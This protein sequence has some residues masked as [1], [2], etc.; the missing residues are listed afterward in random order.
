MIDSTLNPELLYQLQPICEAVKFDDDL[1]IQFD[2]ESV[3]TTS[4]DV[5][6]TSFERDQEDSLTLALRNILY[7]RCYAHPF[8]QNILPYPQRHDETH[9]DLTTELSAA[10]K[11][12]PRWHTHWVVDAITPEGCYWVVKNGERQKLWPGEFICAHG[13]GQAASIGSH[14]HIHRPV[15]ASH[16]QP[17]FY[18]AF[19]ET[20]EP[21][22]DQNELVRFYWNVRVEEAEKLV[23]AI[24][25]EFNRYQIPFRFKCTN[26]SSLFSRVD[27]AVLYLS[28]EHFRLGLH[29]VMDIH[30]AIESALDSDVPL[31]TY[32][33]ASGLS[34][35]QN[36]P[37]NSS[38]GMERCL[39]LA[40]AIRQSHAQASDT[41]QTGVNGVLQQLENDGLNLQKTHL[42]PN[43]RDRF[44][45]HLEGNGYEH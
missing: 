32:A 21:D 26:L 1:N 9:E 42:T 30:N 29:L 37:G 12:Q 31:F 45:Q 16:W 35:A 22:F 24:T 38:F 43:S 28:V 8:S 18:H 2:N 40:K 15:E 23:S 7:Q 14:I 5:Y 10:N 4:H 6:S 20:H 25:S 11:G 13:T 34:F 33:L 19:G 27:T 44:S 36:P 41:E 3:V 39:R 17:G